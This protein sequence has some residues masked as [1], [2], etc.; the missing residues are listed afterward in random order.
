MP[1]RCEHLAGHVDRPGEHQRRLRADIGEGADARARLQPRR[2][3]GLGIA[4]QHGRRAV[5]DARRIAGMVHVV[6]ALQLGM[7]LDGHGVEA[8]LLAHHR[9]RRP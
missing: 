4:D 2:L 8:A 3:A 1:A 6:D 7:R 5:D 9:E